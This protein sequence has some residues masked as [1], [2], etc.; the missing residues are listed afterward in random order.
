MKQKNH[1]PVEVL[2]Y[3]N[4]MGK[5]KCTNTSSEFKALTEVEK[6]KNHTKGKGKVITGIQK[7]V[8]KQLF[9]H[10]SKEGYGTKWGNKINKI[11]VPEQAKNR[12]AKLISHE[13]CLY[14]KLRRW[15]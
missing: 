1:S 3:K 8:Q 13:Q 6:S 10:L 11:H 7:G 4:N 2:H 12:M 5:L 14:A 9:K 15:S